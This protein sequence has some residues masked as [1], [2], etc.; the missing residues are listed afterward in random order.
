[1]GIDIDRKIKKKK[2]NNYGC[3]KPFKIYVSI[4]HSPIS[5]GYNI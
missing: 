5:E 3:I 1:M 4:H 2:K